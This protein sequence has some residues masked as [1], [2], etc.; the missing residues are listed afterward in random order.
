MI[1]KKMHE[2]D[3]RDGYPLALAKPSKPSVGLK[4]KERA[5]TTSDT[6]AP[7]LPTSLPPHPASAAAASD[8][9][10]FP[11]TAAAS[12]AAS[13]APADLSTPRPRQQA[14]LTATA[15]RRPTSWHQAAANP[16]SSVR[17]SRQ[18]SSGSI[19][20]AVPTN[21]PVARPTDSTSPSG[22]APTGTPTLRSQK[23]REFVAGRRGSTASIPRRRSRADLDTPAESR[24]TSAYST[25]SRRG[26]AWLSGEGVGVGGTGTSARRASVPAVP[27]L[28]GAAPSANGQRSESSTDASASAATAKRMQ[29][30]APVKAQQAPHER[31]PTSDL[32]DFLRDSG[33]EMRS[34]EMD[35]L[36]ASARERRRSS[37]AE[38][39]L[40]TAPGAHLFPAGTTSSRSL[41][42]QSQA[43]AH[44]AGLAL[45]TMGDKGDAVEMLCEPQLDGRRGPSVSDDA[46]VP[47][48]VPPKH[49]AR[50]P[51]TPRL[52]AGQPSPSME[53]AALL[54]DTAPDEADDGRGGAGAA[55]A[56]ATAARQAA[57]ERLEAR[58]VSD[59]SSPPDDLRGGSPTAQGVG[60]S[61]SSKASKRWTMSALGSKLLSRP[62]PAVEDPTLKQAESSSSSP[63][64]LGRRASA[65]GSSTAGRWEMVPGPPSLPHPVPPPPITAPAVA[66]PTSSAS[67]PATSD[68]K[69]RPAAPLHRDSVPSIAP[70]SRAPPDA[71]PASSSSPLEYVKLARTKGARMLRAVETKK[72]TYL[73]VLSG[74]EAE[75]IELFTV[76]RPPPA[77]SPLAPAF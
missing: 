72:R 25:Y 50:G 36:L 51:T 35:N 28:P 57:L 27:R 26:S 43:A 8:D 74:E 3:A 12:A 75:R 69:R 41:F 10:Q 44:L 37:V 73:A 5:R 52:E 21:P 6:L 61:P 1:D 9:Y 77:S 23:S 31:S 34:V 32:A 2:V 62:A 47:P 65:G 42:G 38:N 45:Y 19:V 70:S 22:S 58:S 56:A 46:L 49:E 66:S 29:P 54:R 68:R 14:A 48:P 7:P 4:G 39:L 67:C 16:T 13:A 59:N 20:R 11:P 15:R 30:R 17:I 76:R 55:A 24:R 64:Q 60:G 53:L 33:P 18:P 71:H 40:S 63:S